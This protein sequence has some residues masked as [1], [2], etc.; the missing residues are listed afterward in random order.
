MADSNRFV[1]SNVIA[2][3][4]GC[5]TPDVCRPF[6]TKP[7]WIRAARGRAHHRHTSI[8][9]CTR[10]HTRRQ[11]DRQTD[12]QTQTRTRAR[13]HTHTVRARTHTHARAHTHINIHTGQVNRAPGSAVPYA[14]FHQCCPKWMFHG[15]TTHRD[16]KRIGSTQPSAVP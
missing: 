12:R 14:C 7:V 9:T 6:Q 5:C 13:A 4:K 8:N 16:V 10:A 2:K 1:M 15:P 3:S 11:S